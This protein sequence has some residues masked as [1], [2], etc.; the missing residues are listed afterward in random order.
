MA[1]SISALP[2]F[3]ELMSVEEKPNVSDKYTGEGTQG[4]QTAWKSAIR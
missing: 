1:R 2:K 4:L 3:A